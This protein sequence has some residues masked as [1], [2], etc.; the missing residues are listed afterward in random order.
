LL[1]QFKFHYHDDRINGTIWNENAAIYRMP[2][3]PEV[4]AAWGRLSGIKVFPVTRSDLSKIGRDPLEAAQVPPEW[5]YGDDIYPAYLDV[6]HQIHCLNEIRMYAYWSHYYAP[7]YGNDTT[8]F[9]APA[10]HR[11]HLSHCLYIL[12]QD[13]QCR[14]SASVDTFAFISK[15]HPA[16][17]DVRIKKKCASHEALLQWQED[18][19]FLTDSQMKSIK[20]RPDQKYV[21]PPD[22]VDPGL[23]L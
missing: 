2:P 21:L 12:L 18:N 11:Y 16:N 23:D 6:Q 19:H 9:D 5:G 1:D 8:I 3:S 22:G 10:L 13:L 4:D 20:P 15:T 14:P 7:R 17:V